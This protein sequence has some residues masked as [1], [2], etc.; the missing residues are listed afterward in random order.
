MNLIDP[1][2]KEIIEKTKLKRLDDKTL[3]LESNADW[4]EAIEKPL[5]RQR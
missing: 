5:L 3:D 2:L 1:N 4:I